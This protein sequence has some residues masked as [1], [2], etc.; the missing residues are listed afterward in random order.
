MMIRYFWYARFSV[1]M[2]GV[3]CFLLPAQ[4]QVDSPIEEDRPPPVQILKPPPTQIRKPPLSLPSKQSN[5][6]ALR[7]ATRKSQPKPQSRRFSSPKLKG[8]PLELEQIQVARAFLENLNRGN[9]PSQMVSAALDDE[10]RNELVAGRS[11]FLKP[12]QL[13]QLG[14][15]SW[16]PDRSYNLQF[17]RR[18]RDGSDE[19]LHLRLVKEETT[20]RIDAMDPKDMANGSFLGFR[21]DN[22]LPASAERSFNAVRL[23]QLPLLNAD[24]LQEAAELLSNLYLELDKPSRN[25]EVIAQML[26][27]RLSSI[28]T[29]LNAVLIPSN[30]NRFSVVEG[31]SNQSWLEFRLETSNGILWTGRAYFVVQAGHLAIDA[32]GYIKQP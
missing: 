3:L 26:S 14:S 9:W 24:Q 6:V 23:A 13:G 22:Q 27:P 15:G 31:Q 21:R 18:R 11:A 2:A 17:E 29:D 19:V 1:L 10:V 20:W 16:T 25:P 8:V 4:A 5:P 32:L 12:G 7:K 30:L 28:L